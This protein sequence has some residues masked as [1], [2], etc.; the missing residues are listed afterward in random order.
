MTLASRLPSYP[1][2]SYVVVGSSFVLVD[3]T[4][5]TIVDVLWDVFK[6]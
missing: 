4:T 2:H 1:N 5:N 3:T 6:T